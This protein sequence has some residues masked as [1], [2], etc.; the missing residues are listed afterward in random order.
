M[1]EALAGLLRCPRCGA[2]LRLAATERDEREVL[3]GTLTCTACE[4]VSPIAEGI[5]D[6]M[7]DPP[8]VVR[9]EAAGLD[10]FAEEMRATGW[11][12]E[13][14]L[15][16]PDDELGYWKGLR[17]AMDHVV[18]TLDP[19]AG[20]RLLDVGANTC[21]ASALFAE[22]GLEVVALDIALTELQGLRTARW[23]FE[24]RGVYFD[25]VL[26]TMDRTC[27]ADASLDYVFCS[28][29]LHHNDRAQLDAALAEFFRVLRPGGTL[30]VLSEPMRFP[31]RL[32]RDH[33]EEVAQY[34]GNENVYF[35]RQYVRAARRAGFDIELLEPRLPVFM[36]LPLHLG[37]D[38]SAL[39]STKLFAQHMLRR[40]RLGR[41]ALLA[42][43][44]WLGPDT[45]LS[46]LCRRPDHISD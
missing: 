10:R 19:P 42:S 22:R 31:F 15:A 9:R 14:V 12:R 24:G 16:L 33:G 5:A 17:V 45:A 36:G 6:L 41:R 32:K 43:A 37:L 28:Q 39:G 4:H 7:P 44:M 35:Y 27:L 21:W 38:S 2:E 8:E 13:R 11:D 3:T 34:E 25:R 40:T 1:R 30:I 20:A 29:V 26:A 18:A 23:W 46:M